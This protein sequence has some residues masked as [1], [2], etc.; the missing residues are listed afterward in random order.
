MNIQQLLSSARKC[1][2]TF[3]RILFTMIALASFSSGQAI[4]G[5]LTD[6]ES[7]TSI[8]ENDCTITTHSYAWKFTDPAGVAHSFPGVSDL[9]TWSGSERWCLQGPQFSPLST[10]SSDGWYYLQGTTGSATAEKITAAAGYI[11]PK[12][13]IMSIT[14][15]PP[16]GNQSSSVSYGSTSFVG[17]T[18]TNGNSFN[19]NYTFSI[20]V[21]STVGEDSCNP[22]DTGGGSPY[23]G[24][25]GFDGGVQ[26]TGTETNA[27]T[28]ASNTSTTI[29]TSKQ[30][31]LTQIT[32][33]VPDV[34]SPFDHDYDIVWVWLN[35]VA[36]FTIVPGA[37][38]G[39]TTCLYWN[40]YGY[41]WND[42]A[43]TVDVYPLLV[44]Y[45]NGDFKKSDGSS[46]YATDTTCDPGDASVLS[47]SW[48]TTQTFGPG[49]TAAITAADLPNICAADPFCSN[50]GY[51]VTLASG[52]TPPTT[53]DQR[54]TLTPGATQDFP[55]SQAGPNSTKGET[56]V[57][58]QQYS[59]T[60][61]ES[62]GGSYSYSQGVGMEEKIGGSFFGIGVQYDMKQTMT[63]T[64]TDTWQNTVTNTSTQ[65]DI[66]TIT[67]PPC[68]SPTA[69]CNPAYSEP[70]EFTVYQ[71]NLYGTFMFWPNPY[72]SIGPPTP[73]TLSMNQGT[74]A[75]FTIPTTAVAGYAGNVA[76]FSV[77]GLPSGATPTFSPTT[78]AAGT[79]VL[80][81]VTTTLSTPDGTYPLTISATDGSLSF[82]AYATLIVSTGPSF[83][84]SATPSSRT[85][86]VG[87]KTTYTVSTTALN[88]FAGVVSLSLSGLPS[89]ATS[90]FSPASITGAGSSTLTIT[91]T[92]SMAAGTYPL[93]ITGKSG[94]LS[95]TAT[96]TLVANV[97]NFSV[98]A[99]PT[100]QT[101][102]AGG[103]TTYTVS[104][105]ALNG[106][107]GVIS[108]EA[109]GLPAGA[110]A[111]FSPTSITGAGSSTLTI[112]STASIKAGTYTVTISGSSGSLTHT[113]TVKLVVSS[114]DFSLA[115]TPE[116][117]GVAAG[118]KA[119]YTVSTTALGAFTGTVSLSLTGLPAATS[120]GFVPA[121][122]SGAGSSTLTV[123]TSTTT[124]L[125][126]YTLT[127]TGTSGS[128]THTATI[129]L[130]VDAS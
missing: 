41:D 36:L 45:L 18:S 78:G 62:Q 111:D 4:P 25:F 64:W 125:G 15:A 37:C 87:A 48:V 35:P 30:T 1:R 47:R 14:Y 73:A 38:T 99:S 54:F 55:Y 49:Q 106:F 89:G 101:I 122:I 34:Y 100:S 123:T 12:Y 93:T 7:T 70:S 124:P 103:H 63:F 82:F 112:D 83:S 76:S 17:N 104:T 61:S 109:S 120:A 28:L 2:R 26:V 33:G 98:S 126:N 97:P 77:T 108:L 9:I 119:V 81:T 130:T 72:F 5:T 129:V 67:G 95:E 94:N 16:G 110:S 66:A 46:C 50:P 75:S 80:L 105:K 57:Y 44:G 74:S 85:V 6:S 96:V 84:L 91:T 29:T 118:S 127:V 24:L 56:E 11:N 10:W 107:T 53:T 39:S 117:Q 121:S 58:N 79:T 116:S 3:L 43:H 40:G 22:A 90:A 102:S 69:P 128:L 115:V 114:A 32:P 52:V 59:S 71:D 86:T 51:L 23:N 42:P 88:G 68:P 19:Q 65:T 27:W 113:T 60:T 13:K 8:T 21:C 31:S 92:T 20:S